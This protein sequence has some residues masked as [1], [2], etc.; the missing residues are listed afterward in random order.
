MRAALGAAGAGLVVVACCAGPAV[1]VG[2]GAGIGLSGAIGGI[3]AAL[4]VALC[5]AFLLMARARRRRCSTPVSS[6]D[7]PRPQRLASEE[8]N[9]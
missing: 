5:V 4:L 3:G 7:E 2:A 6:R 8:K 9:R 1:L